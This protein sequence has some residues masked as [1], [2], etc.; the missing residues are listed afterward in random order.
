MV[1]GDNTL[2]SLRF[3]VLLHDFSICRKVS[4]VSELMHYFQDLGE[5][6]VKLMLVNETPGLRRGIGGVF[7]RFLRFGE[8]SQ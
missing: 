2:Y 8:P 1:Q 4:Y 6:Y 5:T 3:V 7:L